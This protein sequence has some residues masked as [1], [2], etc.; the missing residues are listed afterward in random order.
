VKHATTGPT[1]EI[2]ALTTVSE[3]TF[4][5]LRRNGLT[6]IFGNPGSNELP[7]L[8]AM[9]EDFRYVLGLHE[10]V[11]T[12]MA[13]GYAQASGNPAFVNLHAAAG[14]GNAMGALTN[15]WYSHSPLVITAG[16]QVRSTVGM[17]VMLSN[18]EAAN[19][20]RPLVKWS[21]EPADPTD[22]VRS[23]SQAIHTAA[24]SPRGPV[25]VS[26]PYDDWK[27]DAGDLN[28]LLQTRTVVQGAALSREQLQALC[29]ALAKSR[30]P[31]LVL[32]PDVDAARANGAA[33]RLAE[34]LRAPVWVAPSAPRCPFPTRHR[35]FRG[36]LPATVA[37]ISELLEGHDLIVVIGAPVF[38]YHQYA[39]GDYLPSGSTLVHITCDPGE[40]ARAPM[41]DAIVADIRSA[42]EALADAV[43]ESDRAQLEPLPLPPLPET[44]GARL[45]PDAVLDAI[46]SIA[47]DDAV[48]VNESTSTLV[49]FWKRIEMKYPGSYYFPAS[50]G[51][52]FGMPAA[53]GVQLADSTR[54]VI[55]VIGD[56][57]ANYSLTALWTA[58][59]ENIPVI[60]IIF[61]NG[62]YGALRN[63]AKRLDATNSPGLDVPD[64][65][66]CALAQ[67]Y[68]VRAHRTENLQ[69]FKSR[70][71]EALESTS[72]VL[73]EVPTSFVSPA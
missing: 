69:E 25:Y 30:N 17:E 18:V 24:M 38:R 52:G 66:F 29:A 57:S 44:Q 10:G 71:A 43:P 2:S 46:N 28:P 9:P 55:A 13:D 41:G 45:S 48:Y 35:N 58:A 61:K 32:G 21:S 14:T 6:I 37:G 50:G 56:G 67:G 65:D 12:G 60:F 20:P 22:V 16:Q 33:V 27:K 40:A 73:L 8:S 4:E 72:P 70:F 54:R 5:L 23:M 47:P 64:I 53:V 15:A 26:V 7:F 49:P 36:I 68:G 62:T 19:L 1:E 42:L 34:K 3:A 31:V 11:V 51:L 59:Q 39:P 63:F